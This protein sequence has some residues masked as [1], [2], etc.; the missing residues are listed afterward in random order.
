MPHN[1]LAAMAVVSVLV[2]LPM[3]ISAQTAAAATNN[4]RDTHSS[5]NA[6]TTQPNARITQRRQSML[7]EMTELTQRGS[8]YRTVNSDAN[9]QT[10]LN[11]PNLNAHFIRQPA[12]SPDELGVLQW[13]VER[14][15]TRN[16][17]TFMVKSVD[18]N[19]R[20]R[21]FPSAQRAAAHMGL[22]PGATFESSMDTSLPQ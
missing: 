21:V 11:D 1:R 22:V 17:N 12:A 10:V 4:N 18:S 6:R 13:K 9:I 19:E 14:V 2:G 15:S 7:T 20:M 16:G 5:P 3:G 8:T